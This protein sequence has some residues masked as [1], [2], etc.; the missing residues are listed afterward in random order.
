MGTISIIFIFKNHL[1]SLSWYSLSTKS[2][3]NL[4]LF[5]WFYPVNYS[6][7]QL[8]FNDNPKMFKAIISLT[9]LHCKLANCSNRFNYT[10]HKSMHKM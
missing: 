9:E 6:N 7:I 2:V 10:F 8:F 4:Y 1:A 5:T 3:L